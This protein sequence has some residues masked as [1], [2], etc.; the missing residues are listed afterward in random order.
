VFRGAVENGQ[1]KVARVE[2]IC[3]IK[4]MGE[5]SEEI[6]GLKIGGTSVASRTVGPLDKFVASQA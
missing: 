2:L 3:S 1:T 6:V 5:T 4:R